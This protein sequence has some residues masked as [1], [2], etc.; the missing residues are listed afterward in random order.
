[1]FSLQNYDLRLS[2]QRGIDYVD[3]LNPYSPSSDLAINCG[4]AYG[5]VFVNGSLYVALPNTSIV[6]KID[7]VSGNTITDITVGYDPRGLCFDGKSVWCANYDVNGVG[8]TISKIDPCTDTVIATLT[9]GKNAGFI[10][11]DGSGNIWVCCLGSTTIYKIDIHTDAITPINLGVAPCAIAYDN[12][13]YMYFATKASAVIKRVRITTN[14][15][16]NLVM[17]SS[18]YGLCSAGD[19]VFGTNFGNK[20][21]RINR[22][23]LAVSTIT[24]PATPTR[25]PGFDGKRVWIPCG[26]SQKTVVIEPSDCGV[27]AV[28]ENC[29]GSNKHV[30]F[31]NNNAFI[32]VNTG[33]L[34]VPLA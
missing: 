8:D 30:A 12:R 33:L 14:V 20:V 22:M 4:G 24:V 6:R 29:N 31:D 7:P 17:P 27:S 25:R 28:F 18:V 1:M 19:F 13:A 10:E 21:Y 16:S 5:V 26:D 11:Y 15:I 34:R 2:L 23:T 9:V 32:S 3:V